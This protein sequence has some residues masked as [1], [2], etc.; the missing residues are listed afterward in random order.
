MRP[1]FGSSGELSIVQNSANNDCYASVVS[2]A[3]VKRKA[4][5]SDTA[6]TISQSGTCVLK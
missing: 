3:R 6:N 4:V 1:L 2:L 5:V